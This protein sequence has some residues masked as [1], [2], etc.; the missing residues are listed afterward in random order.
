V[1]VFISTRIGAPFTSH[2]A[3]LWLPQFKAQAVRT[4]LHQLSRTGKLTSQ[5]SGDG[6]V[7][8]YREIGATQDSRGYGSI[9]VADEFL[10]L[11]YLWAQRGPVSGDRLPAPTGR[12]L[13]DVNE[14]DD[15]LDLGPLGLD[16]GA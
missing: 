12:Y 6:K 7:C 15:L 9:R 5:P 16:G 14:D 3:I 1:E 13:G 10:D 4:H 11:L 2:E 8:V